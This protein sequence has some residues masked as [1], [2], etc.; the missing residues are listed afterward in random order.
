M[1]DTLL[2][3]LREFDEREIRKALRMLKPL[4]ISLLAGEA[5]FMKFRVARGAQMGTT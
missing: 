5:E 4:R 3:N 2:G 1:S